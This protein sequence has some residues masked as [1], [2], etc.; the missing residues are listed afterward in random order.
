MTPLKLCS[1]SWK[2]TGNTTPNGWK[3][4]RQRYPQKGQKKY[5][6]HSASVIKKAWNDFMVVH[7]YLIMAVGVAEVVCVMATYFICNLCNC[8]LTTG[9][10]K[11][12]TQMLHVAGDENQ[13]RLWNMTTVER[14]NSLRVLN[15]KGPPTYD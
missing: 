3:W 11:E 7:V 8:P 2:G 10:Q 1:E 9:K 5:S 4:T 13:S 14:E 6:I 12:C 15:T